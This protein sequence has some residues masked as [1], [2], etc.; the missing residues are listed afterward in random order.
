MHEIVGCL[1][2]ILFILFIIILIVQYFKN[3]Y[4]YPIIESK[5]NITGRRLPN[6][7]ECIEEWI[8][9]NYT[10][11]CTISSI[12]DTNLEKWNNDCQKIIKKSFIMRPRRKQQYIKLKSVVNNDNYAMFNFSFYKVRHSN[13]QITEV[14]ENTI[15]KTNLDIITLDNQLQNINYVSTTNKY[16][17]SNQRKLMTSSLRQKIKIRDNYTCRICGISKQFLDNLCPGL[18]DYLLFEIDHIKPV[19]QGGVT[20]DEDNLQC[21]CWRCNR[22]KGGDKTNEEIASSIDYGID[23]LL[24]R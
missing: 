19:C 16:N 22:A 2:F 3:P 8:I 20:V 1:I 18:G 13:N 17:E 4:D 6:Y 15:V 24:R 23:K 14:V 21:L 5:I 11:G 12:L 10:N 7:D 9:N